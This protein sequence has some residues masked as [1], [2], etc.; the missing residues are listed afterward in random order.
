MTSPRLPLALLAF[1]AFASTRLAA[2]MIDEI[3]V[4]DDS[5]NP[6]G[7]FGLELHLNTTFQGR[8]RP[9]Y[10][11]EI[12]PLHGIRLT[13]E[14]SYGLSHDFEAGLYVPMQR[15]GDGAYDLAGAKLR[16]KWVPLQP[17]EKK[18]GW[19]LGAN[20]E[21]SRLQ[22]RFE[23]GRWTGELRGMIGYRDPEWLVAVDPVFG[24]AMA[25][26][27]RSVRPDFDL[28]VK[29]SH[30]IAK[31]LSFGPEY[32]AGFGPLGRSPAFADQ[33]HSLFLALDVDRA[34]WVFNVGLGRGVSH[35]SDRWTMKFIFEVPW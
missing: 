15:T 17:D 5:I 33:D 2:V 22:P 13:P 29:A 10:P 4:Y 32:Y 24:W 3:Q 19:F 9:D 25:G 18:G 1:A 14:F 23:E 31:G 6:V 12:T 26:P 28:Q 34:P 27:D 16:M 20:Y 30:E 35:A 11:G 8:S 21:L 7:K